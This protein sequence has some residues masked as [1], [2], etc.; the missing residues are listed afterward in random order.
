MIAFVYCSWPVTP[1]TSQ[2]ESMMEEAQQE[3][4]MEEVS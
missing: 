3:S 4:M 1:S 2:Q